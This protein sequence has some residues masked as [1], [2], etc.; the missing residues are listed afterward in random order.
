[1]FKGCYPWIDNPIRTRMDNFIRTRID[2]FNRNRMDNIFIG[3]KIDSLKP[4]FL[5]SCGLG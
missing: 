1:L 3:T 5:I 4:Q 2:N